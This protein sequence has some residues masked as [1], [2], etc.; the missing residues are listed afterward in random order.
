MKNSSLASVLIGAAFG[1]ILDLALPVDAISSER[2]VNRACFIFGDS[3]IFADTRLHVPESRLA[4]YRK[5]RN[6]SSGEEG[7]CSVKTDP[8]GFRWLSCY[9][10]IA[11][12]GGYM[13]SRGDD[14][15]YYLGN[16]IEAVPGIQISTRVWQGSCKVRR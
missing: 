8:P 7:V 11:G 5:I 3:L 15:R 2:I 1:A 12:N 13:S 4:R 6:T 16:V 14:S 9:R 10:D